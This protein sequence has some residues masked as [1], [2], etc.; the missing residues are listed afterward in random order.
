VQDKYLKI[1]HHLFKLFP[2]DSDRWLGY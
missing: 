1:M 2:V